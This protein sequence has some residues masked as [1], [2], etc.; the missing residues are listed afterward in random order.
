MTAAKHVPALPTDDVPT[1]EPR[2]Q[3]TAPDDAA[4]RWRSRSCL[5]VA[6]FIILFP[7]VWMVTTAFKSPSLRLPLYALVPAHPRQ[8]PRGLQSAL[9]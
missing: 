8:L 2:R 4:R 6:A 9:G 7:I 1:A 5:L 3:A